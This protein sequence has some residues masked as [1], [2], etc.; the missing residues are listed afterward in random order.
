[1]RNPTKILACVAMIGLSGCMTV[2]QEREV[3][4]ALV[5]GGLGLVSAK[6]LGADNQWVVV[7]TLAGAA[8]GALVARN[9]ANNT[10][11]YANGD[12]TYYRAPC[13]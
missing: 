12:G 5:G 11:A 10:C 1:M 3:T 7:S 8:A 6:A 9:R 2:E 13:P 4:G